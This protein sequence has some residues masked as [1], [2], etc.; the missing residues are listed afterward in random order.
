M[1]CLPCPFSFSAAASRWHVGAGVA[2]L[3]WRLR[4]RSSGSPP[5]RSTSTLME[6]RTSTNG[7]AVRAGL[8]IP[9]RQQYRLGAEST[10]PRDL[11]GTKSHPPRKDLHL[12]LR[13]SFPLPQ[14]RQYGPATLPSPGNATLAYDYR[15]QPGV[16]AVSVE[17]PGGLPCPRGY[18]NYLEVFSPGTPDARAGYSILIYDVK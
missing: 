8:E 15:P 18:E 14:A 5:P 12:R 13:Q 9:R 7:S 6:S 3:A 1:C 16:Y 17:F 10:R 11:P 2:V 4:Y